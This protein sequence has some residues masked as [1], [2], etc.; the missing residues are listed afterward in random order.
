M[1]SI[2]KIALPAKE[3]SVWELF[4]QLTNAVV[5][6]Q[7]G[8]HDAVFEPRGAKD[9]PW[10]GIVH[11][12]IKPA[13]I[14]LRTDYR[15]NFPH[16]VLGDFCQAICFGAYGNWER[17][18]MG[19]VSD[20]APP[21]APRYDLH[22]DTWSIG[23]VVQDM[24]RLETSPPSIGPKRTFWGVG[25]EYS[26]DLDRAIHALMR[27]NYRDL[28]PLAKF[29]SDLDRMRHQVPEGKGVNSHEAKN[30]AKKPCAAS[31]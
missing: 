31:S 27:S 16:V 14:L 17:Q 24:C 23:N 29:A 4:I 30:A 15:S 1:V 19:G 3:R 18:Y 13:N 5:Y 10:I 22:S 8:I 6:L 9:S 11:R 20:W 26:K 2:L 28:P 7:N 12:D 25:E 21:E